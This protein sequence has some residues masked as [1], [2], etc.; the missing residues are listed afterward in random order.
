M[1]ITSK[2][3]QITEAICIYTKHEMVFLHTDKE[4]YFINDFY[5]VM[6]GMMK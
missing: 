2:V 1:M 6:I 5:M 3:N 4:F